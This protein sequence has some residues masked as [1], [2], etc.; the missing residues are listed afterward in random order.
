MFVQISSYAMQ[1]KNLSISNCPALV[2]SNWHYAYVFK[3]VWFWYV[4]I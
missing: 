1:K 4:L 3:H 2:N